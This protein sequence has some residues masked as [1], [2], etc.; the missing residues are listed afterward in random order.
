M[1]TACWVTGKTAFDY[2][3]EGVALY[4]K[5]LRNYLP[6]E[7][8]V[9]PD[10]KNAKNLSPEL[11]KQKECEQMLAKLNKEDFLVLLDERGR[12]LTSVAFAAWL[13]QKMQLATKRIVFVIGGAYGFSPAMYERADMQLSLS[14][15]T[16]SHQMIR[17]FFVEQLYR[18]MT[19]LKGEPYHNE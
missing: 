12:M 9:F 17:L 4:E 5:R 15:L 10:I 3:N 11:L 7:W 8:L 2:L 18:A 1:K 13:E 6:F 14:S 16:F 19:I